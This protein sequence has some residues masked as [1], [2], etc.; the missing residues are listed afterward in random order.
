VILGNENERRLRRRMHGQALYA[1]SGGCRVL[2]AD[3]PWEFSDALGTRGA[4]ANY[5]VQEASWIER[6][7]LPTFDS[8]GALLFMWRVGAM[9]EEAYRCVRAWGFTPKSEIV[10]RK[11]TTKGNLSFGMG[12][13][14]RWVHEGCIIAVRGKNPVDNHG[15]RS[16]FDAEEPWDEET[17]NRFMQVE[18]LGGT[19][20]ASM[21]NHSQKP[22]E[23]FDIVE[24]LVPQG[25]YVELFARRHRP[26]WFCYGNEL[27]H[28][29]R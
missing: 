3:P 19:F 23:F 15:I 17:N 20:E 9:V 24:H 29:I 4:A 14:T 16:M 13:Y 7:Q 1:G 6:I 27:G 2:V 26:G 12:R 21:S 5:D 25:P 10:W 11:L 18:A 8:S 22:E 28:N